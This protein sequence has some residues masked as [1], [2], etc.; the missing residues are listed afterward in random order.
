M[1]IKVTSCPGMN[2][3]TFIEILI[4]EMLLDGQSLIKKYENIQN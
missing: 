4:L 1:G 3:P 2:N